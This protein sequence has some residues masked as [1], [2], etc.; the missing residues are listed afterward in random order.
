MLRLCCLAYILAAGGGALPRALNAQEPAQC[1]IPAQ[2][3]QNSTPDANSAAAKAPDSPPLIS[4]RDHWQLFLAETF[5]PPTQSGTFFTAA[6]AQLFNSYPKYGNNRIAFAQRV[7]ASAADIASHNF[8]GD[9]LVA[10][11]L[12]E[13]P[14]YF[15]LGEKYSFWRRAGYAVSRAFVIRTDSGSSFNWDNIL[16][17]ALSAGLSNAYY[18]PASRNGGVTLIH[19]GAQVV[20]YGAINL[21]PEFW[22][23]LSRKFHRHHRPANTD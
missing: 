22:P 8:F 15:R 14:R 19:F 17:S 7:G 12:H 11:A 5:G 9:Y 6:F 16:G 23:D 4:G 2:T 21:V 3:D 1:D 13:D 10:S 20:D 18:P